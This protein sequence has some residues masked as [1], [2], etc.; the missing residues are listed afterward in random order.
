MGAQIGERLWPEWFTEQ[1]VE[2]AAKDP[3]LWLSLYQQRPTTEGGTFW[4]REWLHPVPPAICPAPAQLRVYGGSDYAVTAARGDYTVHAVVGLDPEDRP[5]LLDLWRERT[6]SDV[7][8]EAWCELVTF[9]KPM[10]WGEEHGQIISGV[11]PYLE[12]RAKDRRAHTER[13]QFVSR[14][15]K[16]RASAVY[17]RPHRNSWTVVRQ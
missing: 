14:H 13:I 4:R 6:S 1:M 15:D 7:W 17:T 11:G 5:W 8:I 16:G 2:D 9:W 12:R 10:A 3:N